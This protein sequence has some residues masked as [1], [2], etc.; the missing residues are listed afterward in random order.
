MARIAVLCPD[1]LFAS[2]LVAALEAAGHQVWRLETAEQARGAGPE[3]DLLVVDLTTEELDGPELVRSLRETGELG[4]VPTLGFY[5][6]VDQETRRRA[7][8]AGFDRVV[9]RSRMARE[10]VGLSEALLG[11]R[12]M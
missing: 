7:T 3:S 2:K 6:H 5:A 4:V 1:L 8:E 10:A 11:A 12:R 9:P